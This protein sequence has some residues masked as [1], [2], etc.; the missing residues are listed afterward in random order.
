MQ[1]FD[2]KQEFTVIE[3]RLPH[4]TQAGTIAFITWRTWDSMPEKVIRRWQDERSAWLRQHGI[5][6][7]RS[8][9][10]ARLRDRDVKLFAEMK[11]FVADRWNDHLDECH[12][13]CV[14]RIPEIATIVSESLQHF[15]GNRYELTDY[16]VMPNHVHLLVAFPDEQSQLAQCES[17]KHYT[18]VQIN[19]R[20]G[21]KGRFWQQD[22]FDHLVRSPE[23]FTYL[24]RYIVDNPKKAKLPIGESVVYSSRST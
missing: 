21:R 22:A 3:R 16:V 18:A 8:D 5:D 10:E 6:P 12:G 2:P 23:Q 11:H 20:L 4:W 9:W 17:W 15:N 7:T 19:K 14:L 13:S 1:V 24:R